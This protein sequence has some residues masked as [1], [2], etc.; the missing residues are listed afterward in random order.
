MNQV[1]IFFNENIGDP[2]LLLMLA[3]DAKIAKTWRDWGGFWQ[4]LLKKRGCRGFAFRAYLQSYAVVTSPAIFVS[5]QGL[6]FK[7][8]PVELLIWIM[9]CMFYTTQCRILVLGLRAEVFTDCLI[10]I[11]FNS[12]FTPLEVLRKYALREQHDPCFGFLHHVFHTVPHLELGVFASGTLWTV[13]KV[14]NQSI[15]NRFIKFNTFQYNIMW[16]KRPSWRHPSC[17][18]PCRC[19]E[20][21]RGKR[22]SQFFSWRC[23]EGRAGQE[24]RALMHVNAAECAH[25]RKAETCTG[26]KTLKRIQMDSGDWGDLDSLGICSTCSTFVRQQ[27]WDGLRS[28]RSE[29]GWLPDD[30]HCKRSI[31]GCT[32]HVHAQSMYVCGID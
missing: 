21:H 26:C 19:E 8:S 1:L 30:Y 10:P 20:R 3:L 22:L 5:V 28:R 32:V 31:H 23:K 12:D 15:L 18:R 2:S 4:P 17:L 27:R 7:P 9:I 6:K 16:F 14:M 13:N 24:K 11:R 25:H 29:N